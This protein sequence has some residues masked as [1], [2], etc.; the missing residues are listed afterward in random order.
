MV[1][2]ESNR[3]A[4]AG[5]L[6]AEATASWGNSEEEDAAED[7]SESEE[8][9]GDPCYAA[10]ASCFRDT[11]NARYSRYFGHFD[12]TTKIPN[13]RFTYKKPGPDQFASTRTTL[14][15]FSVKVA[16]IRGGLQWP[17][18]VFGRV[19][20]RDT[21]DHNRNMIFYRPRE[22]CQ[23]LT[24]EVP[25][26]KLTGP[27]RAVVLADPATFEVDLKVKGITQ[28]EDECLSFLAVNYIDF[29]SVQSR[30]LKRDYPSK[31]STLEF[32]LGSIVHSVEATIDMRIRRGSW[33][34]GVR[35]Q[36]AARTASIGKA[37]VMLLDSG[38]DKVH[39]A[40]DRSIKL[41][42]SVVSVEIIGE[43]EVCVKAW[44]PGEIVTDKKKVFKPKKESA[45]HDVIDV[46]F[47]AMDVTI[48]WSV[49]SILSI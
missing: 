19:A 48:S 39:V 20:V 36:F 34:D 32:E 17:L 11:W 42:R 27:T 45:S 18:H 7:D 33:P 47:C 15:I 6:P 21:V 28:S 35:A 5:R 26:L 43:L 12:D 38:D 30:L 4:A 16:R 22:S 23:I 49:I 40:G 29:T 2:V 46:G 3:L 41:S 24:Q 44:R 9:E 31:L 10:Q 37:K 13:K 14:Q 25:Y 1:D 8:E